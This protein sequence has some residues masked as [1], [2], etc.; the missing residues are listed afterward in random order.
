[1]SSVSFYN[2]LGV[3]SEATDTEIRASY[4]KLAKESHPDRNTEDPEAVERVR[5]S[6]P[7]TQSKPLLF[8][9]LT[10]HSLTFTILSRYLVV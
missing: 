7:T 1:M 2:L 6:V 5:T 8:A 4:R 9:Y 3:S 10:L